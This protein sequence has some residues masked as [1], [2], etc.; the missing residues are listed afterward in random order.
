M[1]LLQP[2]ESKTLARIVA[3]DFR[4]AQIF[5]RF[6]L[7]YCCK[8]KR[9]LNIAC[10]EKGIQPAEVITEL[11]ALASEQ[12]NTQRFNSWS[13]D[14]LTEYIVQ[15]HHTYVRT[16]LPVIQGHLQ[17]VMNAHGEK[18]PEVA[19]I[20]HR[21]ITL[22]PILVNHLLEEEATVFPL[23]KVVALSRQLNLSEAFIENEL[24][25]YLGNLD[26]E[27]SEVGDILK[28]IQTLSNNFTPPGGACTTFRV[29][30]QELKAF[31]EDMFRHI[32]LENNIL[33]PKAL[34]KYD[35]PNQYLISNN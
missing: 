14:F 34:A 30:Y 17:K 27:H 1:F 9:Q 18:Y 33:F 21:F 2:T 13:V 4:A 22:S 7:D 10:R 25:S 12:N 15:Q 31:Q 19:E 29:L 8:G 20:Q 35:D 3:D 24:E 28:E 23:I 16:M 11:E 26:E 6:G 5:E 32:H